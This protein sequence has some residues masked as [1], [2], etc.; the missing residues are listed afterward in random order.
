MN[1]K[2]MLFAVGISLALV[3]ILAIQAWTTDQR[4]RRMGPPGGQPMRMMGADLPLENSWAHVCFDLGV[5]GK[6]L[7]ELRQ[8]YWQAWEGRSN[9]REDLINNDQKLKLG[10]E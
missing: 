9:V 2:E 1:K 6:H 7:V 8:T 10:S 4:P 3:V 5:E